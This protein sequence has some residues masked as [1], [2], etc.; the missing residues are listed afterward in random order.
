MM[1]KKGLLVLLFLF[2]EGDAPNYQY[3]QGNVGFYEHFQKNGQDQW[4][5]KSQS[6]I[7]F[8]RG[9]TEI[10]NDSFFQNEVF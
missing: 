8:P 5:K 3:I 1:G 9:M 7:I 2:A 6:M 4:Q 10:K